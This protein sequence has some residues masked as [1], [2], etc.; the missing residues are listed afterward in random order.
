MIDEYIKKWVIKA[1][2]DITVVE[3]ELDLPNDEVITSAV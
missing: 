2:E 3:H 1:I